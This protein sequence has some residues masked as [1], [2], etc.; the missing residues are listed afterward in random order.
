MTE[1]LVPLDDVLRA[2]GKTVARPMERAISLR[3][4]S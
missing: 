4:S 2:L 1:K 3:V